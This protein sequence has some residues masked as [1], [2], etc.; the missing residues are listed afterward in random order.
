M[1]LV[2]GR[3]VF[4]AILAVLYAIAIKILTCIFNIFINLLLLIIISQFSIK[5]SRLNKLLI[6]STRN[7]FLIGNI[8]YILSIARRFTV[9]RFISSSVTNR[10]PGCQTY[11]QKK[12]FPLVVT[13][14]PQQSALLFQIKDLYKE[15]YIV[16]IAR[17]FTVS[18]FIPSS[19][20]NRRP[21][22]LQ[23]EIYILS[24]WTFILKQNLDILKLK[25]LVI[26]F[27]ILWFL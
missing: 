17:R 10:R 3:N 15:L 21:G 12:N 8:Q 16:N 27:R 18:G 13:F 14:L 24:L 5:L 23:A 11:R 6:A 2:E 9:S 26:H 25:F 1:A 7:K 4:S 20:T 19:V 22:C